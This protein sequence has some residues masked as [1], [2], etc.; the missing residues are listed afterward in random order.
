MRRHKEG[1][2][3]KGSGGEGR[4]RERKEERGELEVLTRRWTGC[5]TGS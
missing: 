3:D 1:E 4:G 2:E 5:W